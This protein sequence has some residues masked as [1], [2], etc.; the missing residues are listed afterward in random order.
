[1]APP[2]L[3]IFLANTDCTC[4]SSAYYLH[5]LQ[6]GNSGILCSA[7]RSVWK[8]EGSRKTTSDCENIPK[9]NAQRQQKFRQN[10]KK[11]Q[12]SEMLN[13]ARYDR[14]FTWE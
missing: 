6:R 11:I 10:Q 8:G 7:P 4:D 2:S 9:T 1:M 13:L 5:I 14:S 12:Q 3:N